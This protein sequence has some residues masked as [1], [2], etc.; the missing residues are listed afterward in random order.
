MFV[1]LDSMMVPFEVDITN[2]LSQTNGENF[3]NALT[4]HR[5]ILRLRVYNIE[6]NNFWKYARYSFK[7]TFTLSS[8]LEVG[9]LTEIPYR[10]KNSTITNNKKGLTQYSIDLNRKIQV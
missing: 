6:D 9:S 2:W 5:S 8:K 7:T 1:V 3:E 4:I 10:T